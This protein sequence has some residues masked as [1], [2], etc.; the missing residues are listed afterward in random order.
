MSIKEWLICF[1]II[2]IIYAISPPLFIIGVGIFVFYIII[3]FF[4][5]LYWWG[6]DEGHW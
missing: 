1:I 5:D 6:K 3:R 4:A 2:A